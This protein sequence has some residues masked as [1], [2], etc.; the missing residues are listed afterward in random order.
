MKSKKK[1]R[2]EMSKKKDKHIAYD[3]PNSWVYNY[4]AKQKKIMKK[5][6]KQ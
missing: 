6:R 4:A 5:E 2:N 1:A 3:D